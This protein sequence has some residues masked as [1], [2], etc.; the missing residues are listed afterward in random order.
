M[1]VTFR[2]WFGTSVLCCDMSSTG[3]FSF[4]AGEF[5]SR[6]DPRDDGQ[7]A[8]Y[9]QHVRHCSRRP[10][11][12][13]FN[14]LPGIKGRYHCKRQSWRD[15]IH[16]HQERWTGQMHHNQVHVSHFLFYIKSNLKRYWASL[17]LVE[18]TPI[19]TIYVTY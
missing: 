4:C 7:K 10:W 6:R 8:E 2:W 11:Q 3:C 15:T 5:H 13:D 14:G 17:N 18:S 1:R 9:P 19:C 12:I 16:R